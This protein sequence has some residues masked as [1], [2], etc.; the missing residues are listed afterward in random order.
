VRAR[1]WPWAAIAVLAA[2]SRADGQDLEQAAAARPNVVI[3]LADDLSDSDLDAV[4][5][6]HLDALASRGVRFR[7]AYASPTCSPTRRSIMFGTWWGEPSGEPCEPP[8][9]RTPA[10]EQPSL[11]RML[12]EAGYQTALFGKWHVGSNR[13]GPWELAPQAHGFG[14]WRAGMPSNV[15][16][17]GGTDDFN[18]MRVDDGVAKLTSEYNTT[19]IRDEFL[20]WWR[21]DRGPA[22]RF[23]VVAFQA[24]HLPMHVPPAEV[25]PPGYRT[26]RS[27]REKYE[28]AIVSLD[29]VLGEMLAAMEQGPGERAD[30]WVFFMADNGTPGIVAR[31][32]DRRRWKTTAFE[33]GVRVPFIVAGPDVAQ[34]GRESRALV[35]A[36]DLMATIADLVGTTDFVAGAELDS[37]SFAG[38]L[39]GTDEGSRTHVYCDYH[40]DEGPWERAVITQRWKLRKHDDEETFFDLRADPH[41]MSPLRADDPAVAEVVDRLRALLA[42]P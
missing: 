16:R 4:R 3:V 42:D 17:C 27:V 26:P 39:R 14:V 2:A 31:G 10:P 18:W 30:T 35:H 1:C 40:P 12:A 32:A 11:P 13:D 19:A 6:P 15:P 7:R 23:A 37:T 22:P 24:P 20:A 34:R 33:G 29:V 36:V 28:A 41:E 38:I 5:T 21:E 8:E 9:A 25:L